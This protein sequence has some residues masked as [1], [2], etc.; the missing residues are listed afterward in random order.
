MGSEGGSDYGAELL[1]RQLH[2]LHR[3]PPEGVSVGL[4]DDSNIFV[5]EV[6]IVGAPNTFY[7]EG[8]FRAT[9]EFPPDFPNS[10][11]VMRFIS[12]MWHPNVYEDGRVCISILHPPG[13]DEMNDQETAE[14]RWRPI[15]GVEQI[16]L[17]VLSML[18]DANADSPANVDAAV[19]FRDDLEAF[20][21]RVRRCVRKS[22]EE[23]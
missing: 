8:M 12:E 19:Q 23:L 18:G 22:Q 14:E 1:R 13:D 20:K 10:P 6:M 17:S 3:N 4:V 11:P 15:L 2:E 21:K 9:L 16:I 5:W 7:E